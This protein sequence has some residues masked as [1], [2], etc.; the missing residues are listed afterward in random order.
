MVNRIVSFMQ[1]H[2]IFLIPIPIPIFNIYNIDILVRA[3][4]L[5]LDLIL[6]SKDTNIAMAD[7]NP[8]N[9][10]SGLEKPYI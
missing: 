5:F 7:Y 2:S 9:L 3:V 6:F 10:V 8:E 1:E 4:H